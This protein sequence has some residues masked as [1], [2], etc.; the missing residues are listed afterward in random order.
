MENCTVTGHSRRT[1]LFLPAI[2]KQ[3]DLENKKLF[4]ENRTTSRLSLNRHQCPHIPQKKEKKFT[5]DN[6]WF[7]LYQL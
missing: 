2:K 4:C 3:A 7:R 6:L 1:I 5:P